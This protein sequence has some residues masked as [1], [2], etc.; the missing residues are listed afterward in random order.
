MSDVK[1]LA[2][3]REDA[4]QSIVDG[5]A[6]DDADLVQTAKLARRLP[7]IAWGLALLGQDDA[8]LEAH[9]WTREALIIAVDAKCPSRD[10]PLYLVAAHDRHKQRHKAP[11]AAVVADNVQVNIMQQNNFSAEQLA[12][13]PVL[14][15]GKT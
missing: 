4:L 3:L 13:A 1:A 15:L 12:A 10:A 5:I 6:K 2:A 7:S 8:T 14:E 11:E 9:G